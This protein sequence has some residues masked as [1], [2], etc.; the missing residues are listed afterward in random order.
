[1]KVAVISTSDMGG[2]GIA[3]KRLHLALLEYGVASR[4]LTLIKVGPH[5]AAHEFILTE[6]RRKYIH[7]AGLSRITNYLRS[8]FNANDQSKL[9]ARPPGYEHFSFPHSKLR[10]HEHPVVREADLI[11][12]HWVAD[13][14]LDFGSFFLNVN[15]PVI[16]T[17]HDT[18]PF[19][20]G[21]HNVDESTGYLAD[22]YPCIQLKGTGIE[23]KAR[24]N[25]LYK[26]DGLAKVGNA[27]LLIVSPSNWLRR[28]SESSRL[29][30][31][32]S[33][34]TIPNVVDERVYV[35]VDRRAARS[36]LGIT[37][38]ARVVLFVAN[39]I[40]NPRKGFSLLNE[41]LNGLDLPDLV[42]CIAGK[43]VPSELFSAR[44]VNLGF[45]NDAK[46]MAEA[47]SAA[48]VF[49]LPSAGENFPNTILEAHLCGVPVVATRVGG[50]PEQITAGN[51]FT[52]QFGDITALRD[53]IVS[54]LMN[55]GKYVSANIRS[56]CI[57]RFGMKG[58]VNSYISSYKE[59]IGKS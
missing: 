2:A 45:I 12:L 35:P 36:R 41:A 5:I 50:V 54:V 13:G 32:F 37:E 43:T 59:L 58:V 39:D 19:T 40:G 38:T 49:V 23:H 8:L 53:A 17:L 11:H 20:G 10:L 42:I 30:S 47:Y 26:T 1:M 33:H 46:Q 27:R 31:R 57:S 6:K 25:L 51:G 55:S 21:C 29:F 22:C 44:V 9:K 34:K 16:W 4:F 56:E 3:A 24:Q 14:M 48:D 28:L 7:I 18:N 15:K 52:V